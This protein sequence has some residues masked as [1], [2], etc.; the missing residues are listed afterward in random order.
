M[1]ESV[2]RVPN[3]TIEAFR[4]RQDD[5]R[6]EQR[7]RVEDNLEK[8]ELQTVWFSGDLGSVLPSQQIFQEGLHLP[9][10]LPIGSF[11]IENH[12][13]NTAGITVGFGADSAGTITVKPGT[14]KRLP[15]PVHTTSVNVI[16]PSG[17]Q[18]TGIV[19][20]VLTTKLW[21]PATT[22]SI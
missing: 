15:C 6:D 21:S 10:A 5:S 12:G 13:T 9:F 22:T 2:S 1:H 16:A 4:R 7:S 19:F 20:V 17:A 3:E 14:G 11:Y 18:D 8:Q